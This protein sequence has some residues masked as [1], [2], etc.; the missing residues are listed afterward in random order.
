MT[1]RFGWPI[2]IAA[3]GFVIVALANAAMATQSQS[4]GNAS[5]IAIGQNRGSGG[6]LVFSAGDGFTDPE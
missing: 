1:T 2:L 5:V 4:T 6:T 3:F